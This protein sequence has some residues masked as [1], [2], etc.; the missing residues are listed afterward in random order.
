MHWART[1]L[2]LT[3]PN[4]GRGPAST[5]AP[6]YQR[7]MLSQNHTFAAARLEVRRRYVNAGDPDIFWSLLKMRR[8]TVP[9]IFWSAPQPCHLRTERLPLLLAGRRF[10]AKVYNLRATEHAGVTQLVE[11]LLPK[12]AVVGSSPIA[13]SP[14]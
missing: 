1:A 8:G 11:Y 7:F 9:Y 13:R 6:I 14:K 5:F 10:T 3:R 2:P 12:Q 4:L